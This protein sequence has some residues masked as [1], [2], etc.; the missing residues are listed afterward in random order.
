MNRSCAHNIRAV[1]VEEVQQRTAVG[2]GRAEIMDGH[3]IDGTDHLAP[4]E[5]LAQ[6]LRVAVRQLFI[7]ALHRRLLVASILLELSNFGG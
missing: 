6:A 4:L 7:L 5:Q 2:E 3:L 1:V